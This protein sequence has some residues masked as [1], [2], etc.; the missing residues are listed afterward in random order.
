[1]SE[2]DDIDQLLRIRGARARDQLAGE[3]R[4]GQGSV[5]EPEIIRPL[6]S[7][8]DRY[9][10]DRDEPVIG[11]AVLDDLRERGTRQHRRRQVAGV[12]V[13]TLAVMGAW[14]LATTASGPLPTPTLA[15]APRPGLGGGDEAAPQPPDL[16]SSSGRST[17]STTERRPSTSRQPTTSETPEPSTTSPDATAAPT[18]P[19]PMPLPL[20]TARRDLR[21]VDFAAESLVPAERCGPSAPPGDRTRPGVGPPVQVID[22]HYGDLLGDSAHEAVVTVSCPGTSGPL[23]AWLFTADPAAPAGVRWVAPLAPGPD[24]RRELAAQGVTDWELAGSVRIDGDLVVADWLATVPASEPPVVSSV[25]VT[26]RQRW[27]GDGWALE[28]PASIRG[29]PAG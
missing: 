3:P 5:D 4:P 29:G 11:G 13:G 28:A 16:P 20:P 26:L 6:D 21:T 18:R 19:E 25:T 14:A 8:R 1:V 23:S 17:S 12:A 24:A 7:L 15:G 10:R 2:L 27:S 9:A 22:V